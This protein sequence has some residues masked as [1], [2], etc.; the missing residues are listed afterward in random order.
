MKK[1]AD[2]VKRILNMSL[3]QAKLYDD[4]EVKIEHIMIALINDYNNN[5]IRTLEDMD[6]D[7]DILHKKIEKSLVKNKKEDE[8]YDINNDTIPL[9]TTSQ[10]IIKGAEKECDLLK[11]DYLDTQHILLSLLKT[12]NSISGI[13]KNMKITY[14]AC[15]SQV[16]KTIIESSAEPLDTDEDKPFKGYKNQP[17]VKTKSNETPVLDNFSVDITKMAIDGRIDPVIGRDKTIQR[18]AQILARKK[19]NNPVIIGEPGVGKTTIVEGLALKIVNGEA[20]RTLLN[21]R[22]VSL[23]LASLVAG[24]KYRGQFEERIKGVVDELMTVDNVILF[25]DEVHTII[26]AGNSSGSMDAANVLKPALSRGDLQLIG[27]TTL[28]EFREN[29]EKD[30]ALTRRFQQVII[31]PPSV[32]DTI[33]ILNKIKFSYESF[34]KVTY[35][36]ETIDRC[37]KLADRYITD[38]EFPDKAI[39][40]MDE[41]G[42]R[43]QVNAKPPENISKL[44]DKIID[45][46]EDKND[47]VKSQRYE[48][49]ARLRDEE[50]IVTEKLES[51]KSKWNDS[52][53]KKRKIIDPEEVNE[54][55]SIMTGIPLN[56]LSGNQG[57]RLLQMEKDLHGS[58]IGQDEGLI[59]IAQSL[60]RNRVGIRNPKKPIGSFM[61][62]GPTGVGK[63]HMAKKLAEYMFGDEDSLIR[64]DMSEFQEKHSISRLIGSPPGYVGHEDGGQLTEKVRRKPYSII[65]FDEIEKAN[66]EIYNILLQLLDDGQLTDSLGR[67]VN[68]KNC[69]VIMTSN[70]GVKK[71]QDFGTGIGFGTK[72]MVEG[73]SAAKSDILMDE[74]KKHFAPEFLNRLDD[75]VIFK[76]LTKEEIGKI[77]DLEIISLKGRVEE[78]GYGL[79]IN[80]TVKDYLIETGYDKEYGARPLNRA[81]QKYV[82]D[83]VSEEILKGSVEEG[84]TIKVSYVKSKEKI[85]IKVE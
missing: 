29:I 41:V 12:K 59:K 83:P 23:D 32:K 60:R 58:V 57:K 25:L 15:N 66:K 63:T 75:V 5:A 40:I 26:G 39:D 7:I 6:V 70:I 47:V 3:K 45:I 9:N 55:V 35:P 77:V 85:V 1:V 24:T 69:M 81:I 84:Q 43:S 10:N 56:R 49:A 67:K 38:R 65:L 80:K 73:E 16:K 22:I 72:S 42:S 36:Q 50:R 46:K 78:I 13:L 31:E 61:F 17:K 8:M 4:W 79:Q 27:A 52:L 44:E 18:V 33:E 68:F 62:I 34:H 37:V 54:V 14:K 51:E 21:K 48:E 53:D 76:S 2:K 20:P 71:L 64:M 82:E 74:L 30:G 28:D 19:K 11:E